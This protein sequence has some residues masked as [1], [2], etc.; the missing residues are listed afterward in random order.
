MT[1]ISSIGRPFNG[2]T[3]FINTMLLIVVGLVCAAITGEVVVYGQVQAV[4]ARWI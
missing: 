2:S 1:R 3:R 4:V